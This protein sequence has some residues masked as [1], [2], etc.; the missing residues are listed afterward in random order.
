MSALLLP[1][2]TLHLPSREI[3]DPRM[4]RVGRGYPAGS[5]M[6][7]KG[8]VLVPYHAPVRTQVFTV[9][10]SSQPWPDWA[11]YVDGIVIG[12]GG[13]GGN[14]GFGTQGNGGGPGQWN[15]IT[16][17]RA[18]WLA[19]GQPSL[20]FSVSGNVGPNGGIGGSGNAGGSTSIT[21]TGV[22]S[23]TGGGGYAGGGGGNAP[24][25]GVPGNHSY[26]GQTYVG[27]NG[28]GGNGATGAQPGG[29]GN[30]GASTSGGGYGG[31]GG[32]W[33]YAYQ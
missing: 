24:A 21:L 16:W 30:G 2:R 23:V 22:S 25:G 14:G 29:G 5:L 6:P 11:N 26:N 9:G 3:I 18:Q 8:K 27:A 19:A 15:H 17:T 12:G 10:A 32:A 33:I 4:V 31:A 28:V 13:S 20:S 1:D 7:R